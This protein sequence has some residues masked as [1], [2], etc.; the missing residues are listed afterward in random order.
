[1][2]IQTV[3]AAFLMLPTMCFAQNYQISSPMPVG[4]APIY[5][6]PYNPYQAAQTQTAPAPVAQEPQAAM[7]YP[8]QGPAM[9]C[10]SGGGCDSS[11][12]GNFFSNG[13]GFDGGLSGPCCGSGCGDVCCKGSYFTMFVGSSEMDDQTS[14]GYQRDLNIDFNQGY[15]IGGAIGRR[16]CRNVR[17]ELEYAFR[18]QTPDT[19]VFNGNPQNNVRGLQNSHAGMLN[20][21]YDMLLGAGKFVPYIGGGI[22]VASVDSR[23]R[24]G[25]GVATL[26]GD[27]SGVA[28]QWMAGLSYR[29]RPNMEMFVE[30]RFFEVDDPKLNRFGGPAIGTGGPSTMAN[31]NILLESE[32]ISQDIFAGIR[33]N[34]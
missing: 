28:Y 1:M 12:G 13:S 4:G 25:N 19:V 14:T 26:D 9:A 31:P 21:A 27:D 34:Y 11:V 2:K 33:F 8:M 15:A 18:S 3:L 32:Y 7:N 29:A 17:M 20:V 16:V 6:Q 30:Y 22:G 24:Y 10:D 5:A 23:V